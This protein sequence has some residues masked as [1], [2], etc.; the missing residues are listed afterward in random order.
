[1]ISGGETAMVQLKMINKSTK[2]QT[3]G[4]FDITLVRIDQ[5]IIQQFID[6]TFGAEYFTEIISI[7]KTA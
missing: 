5:P 6:K 1:M 4:R 3:S 2:V 7:T